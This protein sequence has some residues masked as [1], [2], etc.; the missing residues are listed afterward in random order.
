MLLPCQYVFV[1]CKNYSSD[2]A[3]PELD[4]LSG[5]FSVNRGKVGFLI[6]RNFINRALFIKRCRDTYKDGR[7]LI[8]PLA[9]QDIINLLDNHNEYNDA[10]FDKYLSDIIREIAID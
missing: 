6:C 8:I 9:D 10:F 4:Q 7:G 5:R 3:N 1:E 2:P